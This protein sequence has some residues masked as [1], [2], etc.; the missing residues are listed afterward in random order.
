MIENENN[1]DDIG[2][3][4]DYINLL[5]SQFYEDNILWKGQSISDP[6]TMPIPPVSSTRF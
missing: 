3:D 4:A 5:L 2:L 1:D 6:A